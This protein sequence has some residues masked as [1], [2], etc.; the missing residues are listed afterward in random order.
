MKPKLRRLAVATVALTVGWGAA[1]L[2]AAS[3]DRAETHHIITA[4]QLREAVYDALAFEMMSGR[5][6]L[7]IID[8]RSRSAF[9]TGHIP[10]AIHLAAE[11]VIAPESAA[12]SDAKPACHLAGRL[13]RHGIA[14]DADIVLYGDRGGPGAAQM[15]R[16]L[17]HLGHRTVRVLHGGLQAWTEH[18][19]GLTGNAAA[20][21]PT[22]T[23]G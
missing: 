13:E 7:E 16:A 12:G 21:S 9:E 11:E 20:G 18:G 6:T 15:A 14:K 23:G 17:R 1:T 19:G 8:V 2:D 4:V 5:R 22:V 10:R 3:G